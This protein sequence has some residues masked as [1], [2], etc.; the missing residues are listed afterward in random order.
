MGDYHG[1]V[2]GTVPMHVVGGEGGEVDVGAE[3]DG[4]QLQR[5]QRQPS[6]G[7]REWYVHHNQ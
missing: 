6:C 1:D 2:S 5:E 4:L 3:V 7:I